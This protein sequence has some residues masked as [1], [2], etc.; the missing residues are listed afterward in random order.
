MSALFEWVKLY[1]YYKTGLFL[2]IILII[3][4]LGS[5]SSLSGLFAIIGIPYSI[6]ILCVPIVIWIIVWLYFQWKFPVTETNKKGVYIAIQTEN[7]KQKKRIKNDFVKTMQNLSHDHKI[8]HKIEIHFLN[9]FQ[10]NKLIRIIRISELKKLEIIEGGSSE[11]NSGSYKEI[12]TYKNLTQRINATYII[13]GDIRLRK[14]NGDKYKLRLNGIVNH[15]GVDKSVAQKLSDEFSSAFIRNIIFDENNESDGFDT[16]A[17][18]NF[19]PALYI[20]GITCFLSGDLFLAQKF[21]K[22]VDQKITI[23]IRK[24]P[25]LVKAQKSIKELLD[26]E[27]FWIAQGYLKSDEHYIEE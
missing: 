1:F 12:N 4:L 17:E 5:L 24:Y 7:N 22:L 19:I 8:N 27:S 13:W 10:S 20:I 16:L 9:E 25:Y 15:S 14:K 6:L 26:L 11:S 18:I 21:H 2:G 3:L 23:V